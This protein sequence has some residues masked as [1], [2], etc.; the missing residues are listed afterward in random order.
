MGKNCIMEL[1][2]HS[3]K[4]I[5]RV[6][7]HKEDGLVDDLREKA[8]E[9]VECTKDDLTEMVQSESHQSYVAAVYEKPSDD[10]PAFLKKA[11]EK[12][13]V[14]MLDS[15]SDPQNLGALLRAAECFAVDAVVWSKNR[16]VD[17]TPTVSKTSVGA[18]ELVPILKVANLAEA[19]RRFQ[20]EGYHVVTAELDDEAVS[21]NDFDFPE[22][23]LLI[24]GSEGKGIQQLLSTIA[25]TKIMIPMKGRIQS[26]NVSQATTALLVK[27]STHK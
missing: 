2:K 8:I 14:L 23:T 10:L 27:A 26:L 25:D 19:A 16:G 1:L 22:R 5:V 6:Y 12:S 4:R 24:V 13:L 7:T 17:L 11:E 9:I 21:L 15:I 18:S 3:P 20:K